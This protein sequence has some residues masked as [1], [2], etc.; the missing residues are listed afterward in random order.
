MLAALWKPYS[1][2]E[3]A[4]TSRLEFGP[5]R[6]ASWR[7]ERVEEKGFRLISVRDNN[8]AEKDFRRGGIE[9]VVHTDYIVGG[10]YR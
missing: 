3:E 6:L 1:T 9:R 7:L 2:L 5:W 8:N 4:S 10:G